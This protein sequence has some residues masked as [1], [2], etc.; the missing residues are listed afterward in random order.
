MDYPDSCAGRSEEL[1]LP[2]FLKGYHMERPFTEI[3]KESYPYLYAIIHAFWSQD[4]KWNDNSLLHAIEKGQVEDVRRWLKEI[5]RRI[6]QFNL[7]LYKA[8]RCCARPNALPS[9]RYRGIRS[10]RMRRNSEMIMSAKA[11]SNPALRLAVSF[12]KEMEGVD[13]DYQW[14]KK[15]SALLQEIQDTQLPDGLLSL[16]YIGQMGMVVKWKGHILCLDPVLGAM[17]GPDGEDRRNY[18]L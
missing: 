10:A 18:S 9:I 14:Y 13:M 1:I 2:A 17:P 12:E 6:H 16:W 8:V 11:D 5:H 4:I 3:Q 15:G 7:L